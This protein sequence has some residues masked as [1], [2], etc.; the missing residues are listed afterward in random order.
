MKSRI[1]I[2][3]IGLGVD[4]EEK[5]THNPV[6]QE[7]S[8]PIVIGDE[9]EMNAVDNEKEPEPIDAE[10]YE[11]EEQYVEEEYEEEYIDPN[12]R[13]VFVPEE[14]PKV[15][16]RMVVRTI[17]FVV[18]IINAILAMFGI[19]GDLTVDQETL[20]A[21]ISGAFLFGS[22]IVAYFKNN[23]LTKQARKKSAVEDQIDDI[24]RRGSKKNK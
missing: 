23:N 7:V 15:E 16:P 21:V 6:N 14:A 3:V 18:A 11:E 9:E 24:A 17:V 2:D 20:Y 13:E 12:K 1:E 19:A 8:N 10:E 4:E 5:E 22:G